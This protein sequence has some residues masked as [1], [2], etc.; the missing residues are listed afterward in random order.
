MYPARST[1]IYTKNSLEVEDVQQAMDEEGIV[2]WRGLNTGRGTE[3][4]GHRWVFMVAQ[5]MSSHM[6]LGGALVDW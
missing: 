4:N 5:G 2:F 1:T 3:S 6:E